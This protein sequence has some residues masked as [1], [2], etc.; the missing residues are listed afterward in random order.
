MPTKIVK[1]RGAGRGKIVAVLIDYKKT[2]SGDKPHKPLLSAIKKRVARNSYGRI[3]TR[4][5]ANPV[6]RRIY[7]IID[8]S[9]LDKKGIPA[10]VETLEYDPNRTAFIMLCLYKDGARRYHLAPEGVKGGDKI[11]CDD[12]GPMKFGNRYP[13]KNILSGTEVC[14]VELTPRG[15]GKMGRSAGSK[16]TI[17]GFDEKYCTI[18]MASGEMR[19]VSKEC[20]ATIGIVSNADHRN[21]RI[22]KAGRSRW[23]G[24]RP[25]VRASAMNPR[26]HPYGGGEGRTQRGTKRPKTKWGKVTGGRRTRRSKNPYNTLIIKRRIKKKRK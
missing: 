15:K 12:Q 7:R 6:H 18:K 26:D 16:A 10:I 21:V 1:S 5:R 20:F 22:G 11:I 3:T 25:R 2:L 14:E 24:Q 9:R 13:L 8:F 19:K 23:K 4:F 17:M